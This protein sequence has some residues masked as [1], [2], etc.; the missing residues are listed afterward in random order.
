MRTPILGQSYVA[1]SPNAAA[2]RMVN[3]FPEAL[4]EGRDAAWLQRAPGLRLLT[5]LGTGP[6]IGRAHV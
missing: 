5:T 1:R 2:N 3:L 6:E 4:I